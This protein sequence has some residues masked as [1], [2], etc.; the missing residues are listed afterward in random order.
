M[1][2]P[3][4][5]MSRRIHVLGTTAALVALA[6]AILASCLI[7]QRPNDFQNRQ[8]HLLHYHATKL[9]QGQ[10]VALNDVEV[11]MGRK[12]DLIFPPVGNQ[13]AWRWRWL[14]PETSYGID[15]AGFTPDD[16]GISY[17]HSAWPRPRSPLNRLRDWFGW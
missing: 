4:I 15:V 10:T 1:N 11:I 14:D 2:T 12:A 7:C 3:S 8:Q 5:N 6:L 13:G 9:Q 17:K 16:V